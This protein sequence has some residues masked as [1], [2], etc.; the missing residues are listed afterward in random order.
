MVI[1]FEI[2]RML[3]DFSFRFPFLH[4]PTKSLK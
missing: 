4:L 3:F 1:T 2:L